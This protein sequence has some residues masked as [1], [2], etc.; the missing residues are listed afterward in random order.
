LSALDLATGAVRWRVAAPVAKCHWTA[1]PCLNAFVQAATVM[2]GIVFA[3][4]LD[5]HL[6]AYDTARGLLRWDF[7]TGRRFVTVNRVAASGGSLDLGGAVLAGGMLLVNSGY[8]RLVGQP[9]N[10]LLAL[11]IAG[12]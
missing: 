6:R 1:K 5:G 11:S 12:H 2:P 8:G 3:G 9:G 7:D 4:S 10:V